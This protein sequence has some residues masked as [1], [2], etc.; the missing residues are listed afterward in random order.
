MM[1]FNEAV[2]ICKEFGGGRLLEGLVFIRELL[3]AERD[4]EAV[5]EITL[6][7]RMAYNIVVTKMRPLFV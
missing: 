1:T 7:E 6:E 2:E 5:I 4:E 3:I